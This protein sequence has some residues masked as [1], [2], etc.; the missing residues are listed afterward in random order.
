MFENQFANLSMFFDN[1][2]SQTKLPCIVNVD[3][4]GS[5]GTSTGFTAPI[6]EVENGIHAFKKSLENDNQAKM[7]VD[8]L[9]MKFNSSVSVV[10]EFSKV[11]DIVIPS[12]TASGTTALCESIIKSIDKLDERKKQYRSIGVDYY[13][14]WIW[15]FTD[16]EPTDMDK[17]KEMLDKLEYQIKNKKLS[18]FIV[19]VKG[20]NKNK[21]VS[22]FK[23]Y[24]TIIEIDGAEY[25]EFFKWLSNSVNR[26]I[27]SKVGD[28]IELPDLPENTRVINI[29]A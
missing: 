14:P 13:R 11:E 18:L 8:C 6:K 3:V 4:S 15:V 1:Y 27:D 26:V 17:S 28:A 16:G 20:Y 9:L 5:M 25:V 19:G 23:D 22:L 21:I 2:P 24:A 10:Q 29:I 7:A 12:F